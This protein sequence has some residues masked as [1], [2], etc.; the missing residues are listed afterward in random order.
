MSSLC[1]AVE[2]EVVGV[3]GYSD[4]TRPESAAIIRKLRANGR[5]K[6]VLLSG[7][8]NE[9]AQ[10]VARDVG[11]D[12]ALGSLLPDQKANYVREL[13]AKGHVVAMVGD[14]INDAPAL[15]LADVGIS[16]AGSTEVALETA[17]VILLEG[18]LVRLPRAFA[19]SDQP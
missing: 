6:V 8:S 1:V 12:E 16:I 19:I 14:G 5:R 3:I 10:K 2:G 4:G 7:D 9:V 13:K 15:A 18:G 17:D 11:I